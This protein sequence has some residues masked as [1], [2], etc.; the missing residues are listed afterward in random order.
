MPPTSR[1]T[2][3]ADLADRY[4]FGEL[5]VTHEQNLVLPT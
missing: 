5:R 2:L 4:G 1:W 3:V